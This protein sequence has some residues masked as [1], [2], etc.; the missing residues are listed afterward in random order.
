MPL[1]FKTEMKTG[2]N[3]SG[4]LE[5]YNC[6][7][8]FLSLFC[9]RVCLRLYDVFRSCEDLRV[10]VPKFLTSSSIR[11]GQR[12][13]FHAAS[14]PCGAVGRG[15]PAVSTSCWLLASAQ[16]GPWPHRRQ[17]TSSLKRV[18]WSCAALRCEAAGLRWCVLLWNFLEPRGYVD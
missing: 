13:G 17:I 15:C 9:S 1:H 18:P 2:S 3:N 6:K 11:S 10:Q 14:Q 16:T 4:C 5:L 7:Y 8:S 12:V